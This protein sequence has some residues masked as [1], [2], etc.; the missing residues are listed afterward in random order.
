MCDWTCTYSENAR[1][2]L[3][4]SIYQIVWR[5]SHAFTSLFLRNLDLWATLPNGEGT[6]V[7]MQKVLECTHQNS[8]WHCLRRTWPLPTARVKLSMIRCEKYWFRLLRQPHNFYSKQAYIMLVGFHEK[9]NTGWASRIRLL[10]CR[11]GFGR[12]WLYECGNESVFL[13]MLQGRLHFAKSFVRI[14]SVA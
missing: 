14:G 6:R 13:K 3:P 4:K 5:T 12:V 10:L 8:Q 1:L 7:C 2:H 9:G 11:A